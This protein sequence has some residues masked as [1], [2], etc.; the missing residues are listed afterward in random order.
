MPGA[1]LAAPVQCENF[2][3]APDR[4]AADFSGAKM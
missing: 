1:A 3:R 4:R 2:G